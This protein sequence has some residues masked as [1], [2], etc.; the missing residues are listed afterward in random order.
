MRQIAVFFTT[1]ALALAAVSVSA[2]DL[3]SETID[4]WANTMSEIEVWAQENEISDADMVDP[5]DPTNLESSM[6]MAARNHDGMQDIITSNGFSDGDEWASTGA[7]IVNAYGAVVMEEDD[8]G[9][10]SEMQEQMEAQ[11]AQLEQDPNI[12][13][14]QMGM[15]REQMDNALAMMQR[16]SEAPDADK[17]AVRD[18]RARLDELFE[19]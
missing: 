2:S 6:A 8:A 4:N 10:Y 1:L 12:T 7:R 11:L 16:M 3:D 19:Q 9:S 17:Q 14:E 13:E 18:N 15:I 5:D